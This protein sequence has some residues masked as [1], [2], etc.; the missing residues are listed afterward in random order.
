MSPADGT[1]PSARAGVTVSTPAEL[2]ALPVG[3]V[4]LTD[5]KRLD[6][7]GPGSYRLSFQRLYD[8]EWHR[9]G[10]SRGTDVEYV[11]PATVLFRPDAPQPAVACRV[12]GGAA[13]HEHD[14]SY[15]LKRA[16]AGATAD[17][18]SICD[19]CAGGVRA[20]ER[21]AEQWR[22]ARLWR[23]HLSEQPR[24]RRASFDAGWDAALAAA[25]DGEAER[26]C[27]TCG[28]DGATYE[29]VRIGQPPTPF[30][31]ATCQGDGV[32]CRTGSGE[33]E[34]HWRD[35]STDVQQQAGIEHWRCTDPGC[36]ATRTVDL[37][38]GEAVDREALIA[39]LAGVTP[40]EWAAEGRAHIRN[41]LTRT[42]GDMA[43]RILALLAARGDAATPTVTAE[44]VAAA[45]CEPWHRDPYGTGWP[46]VGETRFC[47]RC[48]EQAQ[49]VIRREA[50][51]LPQVEVGYGHMSEHPDARGLRRAADL[52]EPLIDPDGGPDA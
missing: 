24:A 9:P 29:Q 14:C 25:G 6:A 26:A 49:R 27:P 28:G 16:A 23:E 41:I 45:F 52:I 51:R 46:L 32:V 18:E 35:D 42:Y 36:D 4:V 7:R 11:V 19:E 1:Y 2:D 47:G 13:D 10:R 37:R 48:I 39:V 33:A 30:V 15:C 44:Q 8:G 43:D 34:H 22:R 31:C 50:A 38:A 3:S 5:G 21:E 20:V 17:G 12:C 40:E